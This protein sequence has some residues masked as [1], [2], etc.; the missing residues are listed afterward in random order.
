M[1]KSS[2]RIGVGLAGAAFLSLVVAVTVALAD[3]EP[4]PVAG[5]S[6]V[7]LAVNDLDHGMYG[8]IKKFVET[9]PG[10]DKADVFKIMR[11]RA[12]IMAECGN[13]LMG[14]SPPRGADDAA[15]MTKWKQ[16]CANFRDVCKTL[17]K[18]L[19]MKKAGK[20]S[21]AIKAVDNQC[22]ACHDDHKSK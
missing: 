18:A 22:T 15:G 14:Q 13:I 1:S 19:A 7:M 10:K 3:A 16:H 12:Q 6:N 4:K 21:T 2:I 9:N 11:S 8:Q 20:C 5:I 17:S